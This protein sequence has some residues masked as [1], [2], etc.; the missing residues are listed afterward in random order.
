MNYTCWRRDV[1]RR[2]DRGIS[3]HLHKVERREV[4][5]QKVE[6]PKAERQKVKWQKVERQKVEWQKVEWPNVERQKVEKYRTP[7]A[8]SDQTSKMTRIFIQ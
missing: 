2:V 1:Q 8:E 6:W 4:E 7:N 5:W 3:I